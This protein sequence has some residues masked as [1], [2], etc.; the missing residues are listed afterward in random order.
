MAIPYPPILRRLLDHIADA[1]KHGDIAAHNVDATAHENRFKPVNASL[2]TLT[3]QVNNAAAGVTSVQNQ[4]TALSQTVAGLAGSIGGISGGNT[5]R[6]AS[7]SVTIPDYHTG[8]TSF[9]ISPV[10]ENNVYLWI[11]DVVTRPGDDDHGEERGVIFGVTQHI[12]NKYGRYSYI[13]IG[14]D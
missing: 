6:A 4:V 3:S 10:G 1:G 9:T 14:W 5:C 7:G 12:S 11:G 8:Q 13:V 2:S